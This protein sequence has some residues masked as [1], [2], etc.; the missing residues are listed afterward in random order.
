MLILFKSAANVSDFMG[1]YTLALLKSNTYNSSCQFCYL[2]LS[3]KMY[4]IGYS[5][6]WSTYVEMGGYNAGRFRDYYHARG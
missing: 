4:E 1:Y 3:E 5:F 2:A 6:T